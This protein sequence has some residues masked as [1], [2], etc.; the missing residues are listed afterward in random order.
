MINKIKKNLRIII[1]IPARLKSVRLRK[2]LLK[3]I[4]KIPMIIRVAKNAEKLKIGRVIVGTDSK[5]ILKLCTENEIECI[6]TNKN[7]KSGTDR[8]HEVYTMIDENYDLIINL[9]GDLPLFKRDLFKEM[10]NLFNDKSVDIGSAVCDLDDIE[11]E[12]ENIVK[13]EVIL[14]NFNTGT[15]LD[16]CRKIDKNANFYHHIGV[17]VY[18]PLTLEKFVQLKQTKNELERSLE[19][20]RALDNNYKI[21]LVKVLYNPPSVDTE[22]DLQKIRLIF[23][24]NNF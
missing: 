21:K 4:D 15:A 22:K 5:E 24:K 20:M 7:H 8:V 12:D 6:L 23:K 14:N 19:Q 1:I 2:K 16:F 10:I 18:K 11:I 17:Y 13:A 3:K 9:Q